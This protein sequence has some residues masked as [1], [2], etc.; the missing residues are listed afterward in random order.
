M[1]RLSVSFLTLILLA[2]VACAHKGPAI[3]GAPDAGMSRRGK[4]AKG[5]LPGDATIK[6]PEVAYNMA[7][8]FAGQGNMEGAHHYIALASKLRTD[9]KYSYTNG[10]FYLSEGKYHE[11]LDYLQLAMKQG[12]GTQENRLAVLNAMGACHMELG[13]NEEALKLF[14]QVVNSNGL[15]SRYESYYN[16]GVIYMREKKYL[17]AEAVFLK[18]IDENPRYYKAYNKLG[19]IKSTENKWGDAALNFKKALDLLK[20]DYQA[21]QSDGAEIYYHYGEALYQEKL[22]PQARSALLEVLK[23]APEGRFGR[24]A[25]A[26]LAKIGGG[27]L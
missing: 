21:Q 15:F 8:E 25:K 5:E 18:V 24:S 6:N 11:A 14:R 27:D 22:Y 1:K 17:D 16:M 3:P 10:L 9:S 26:I 19:I 23:I 4:A 13:E 12:P 20:G 7:L 2:A